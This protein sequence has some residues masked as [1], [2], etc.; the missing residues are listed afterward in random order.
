MRTYKRNVPDINTSSDLNKSNKY[1]TQL[2]FKGIKEE[3]NIYSIDQESLSDALNVYVDEE[4]HLTSRPS[5]QNDLSTKDLPYVISAQIY[6]QH[7]S[8]IEVHDAGKYTVYVLETYRIVGTNNLT[9]IY[10]IYILPKGY[11]KTEL[12][13]N[14][15]LKNLTD[16]HISIVD[17]YIICFNKDAFI[18]DSSGIKK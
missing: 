7:Y 17:N 4:N 2:N 5:L 18:D 11:D 16:Y 13:H 1:L 9:S 14:S 10:N 8:L 6:G 12:P 15:H 3:E